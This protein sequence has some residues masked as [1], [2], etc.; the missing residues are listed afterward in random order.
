MIRSVEDVKPLFDFIL[1]REYKAGMTGGGIYIPD[2]AS[3]ENRQFEVCAVGPGKQLDNGEIRP[4]SLAV[5]DIVIF[6]AAPVFEVRIH[7][8]TAGIKYVLMN[9]GS[10]VAKVGHVTI[11]QGAQLQDPDVE[12]F[13]GD[14]ELTAEPF[15]EQSS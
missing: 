2:N 8:N 13:V 5:G 4:M 1:V 7:T 14:G 11:G 15:I 3:A 10:V 6:P 9:E 12:R